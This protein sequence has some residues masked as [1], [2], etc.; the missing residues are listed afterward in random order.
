MSQEDSKQVE[1]GMELKLEDGLTHPPRVPTLC[2]S[3]SGTTAAEAAI[4]SRSV[5]QGGDHGPR[6]YLS[7]MV[8][9]DTLPCR[10]FGSARKP[11]QWQ[12]LDPSYS[13]KKYI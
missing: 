3:V 7:R 12:S 9:P 6:I 4:L 10:H 8:A 2:R 13:Y 11:Q 1:Y 5:R